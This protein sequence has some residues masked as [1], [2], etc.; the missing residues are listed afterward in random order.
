MG[1]D[2]WEI[3]GT[4]PDNEKLGSFFVVSSTASSVASSEVAALPDSFVSQPLGG[5]DVG[6][7]P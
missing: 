5:H 3:P 6:R 7:L 4:G 2:T 1:A